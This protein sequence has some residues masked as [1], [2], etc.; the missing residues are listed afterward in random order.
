[1][2]VSADENKGTWTHIAPEL[3]YPEKFGLRDGRVS[4]QADIYAFGMVVYEVLTGCA[5]FGRE[6]RRIAELIMR[7]VEGARPSKPEGAEDAGFGRGTWELVNQCWDGDRD[8]RPI[9]EDV[10]KHFQR[11]ARTSTV[12]PPGPVT[13]PSGFGSEPDHNSGRVGDSG[14]SLGT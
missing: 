1:M 7:V 12:I 13:K 3:L 10:Y 14:K 9:V 6:G 11:V 4:K 5:P 2:P 8:G